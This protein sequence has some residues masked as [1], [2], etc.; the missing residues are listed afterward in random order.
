[1]AL[2]RI[3]NIYICTSVQIRNKAYTFH[4]KKKNPVVFC[5]YIGIPDFH[6]NCWP[7]SLSTFNRAEREGEILAT[8]HKHMRT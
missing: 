7:K 3:S 5:F 8:L 2:L 6:F 1:M 4:S